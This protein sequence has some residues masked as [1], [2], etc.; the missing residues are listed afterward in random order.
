MKRHARVRQRRRRRVAQQSDGAHARA[1]QDRPEQRQRQGLPPEARF[2]RPP[3]HAHLQARAEA[4]QPAAPMDDPVRVRPQIG[5]ARREVRRFGPPGVHHGPE[6]RPRP[7]QGLVMHV[8]AFQRG[9][10]LPSAVAHPPQMRDDADARERPFGQPPPPG[11]DRQDHFRPC[12]VHGRQHLREQDLVLDL[13][14]TDD[15]Q[16]ALDRRPRLPR[17]RGDLDVDPGPRSRPGPLRQGVQ[18]VLDRTRSQETPRM[19]GEDAGPV[20]FAGR[21]HGGGALGQR[22]LALVVAEEQGLGQPGPGRRGGGILAQ[23]LL[24]EDHGLAAAA[25]RAQ[26]LAQGEPQAR[27]LRIGLQGPPE[28]VARA[29][30][31]RLADLRPG[32]VDDRVL[33]ADPRLHRHGQEVL[34]RRVLFQ[35]QGGLA[36]RSQQ[37]ARVGRELDRLAKGGERLGVVAPGEGG[38]RV[39]PPRGLVV[40]PPRRRLARRLLSGVDLALRQERLGPLGES[41][42]VLFWRCRGIRHHPFFRAAENRAG[43]ETCL[44]SC[45]IG[46]DWRWMRRPN[47]QFSSA[48]S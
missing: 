46:E 41:Q 18:T 40:L 29:V 2:G 21:G 15:Q 34:R 35:H 45:S 1:G 24:E 27:A 30:E 6:A 10:Q 14:L 44:L 38:A 16:P 20:P 47:P 13:L 19:S 33:A 7:D 26:D 42:A 9:G 17:P 43:M 22:P 23:R 36:H 12:A 25:F 37:V 3:V 48:P 28:R 4:R 11:V 39:D 32:Q 8:R 31:G 5:P